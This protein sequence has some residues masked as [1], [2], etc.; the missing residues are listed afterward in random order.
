MELVAEIQ[1]LKVLVGIHAGLVSLGKMS[2][3]PDL[4]REVLIVVS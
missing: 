3:V 2:E 1:D 4:L